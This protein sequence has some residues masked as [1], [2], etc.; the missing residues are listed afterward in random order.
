VDAA[1][2]TRTSAPATSTDS[3]KS[4]VAIRLSEVP[5]SDHRPV[6]SIDGLLLS[7]D[8]MFV[9]KITGAAA[10]M[11][12][13]IEVIGTVDGLAIHAGHIAPRA[14]FLDLNWPELDPNVVIQQLPSNP[15]PVLI[16]FGSHVD[17]ARLN[18]ASS[19]GCDE[20]LPRSKFSATLPELL[21][22]VLGTSS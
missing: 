18:Q 8:L 9:S 1:G 20:V 6:T 21:T 3:S 12:W 13:R 7:R 5:S 2:S 16:A 15:R 22:R 17:T 11:G 10:A 14:V 19:A 4:K